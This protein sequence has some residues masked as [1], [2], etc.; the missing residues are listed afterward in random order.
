MK[1]TELEAINHHLQG[2][3]DCSDMANLFCLLKMGHCCQQQNKRMGALMSSFRRANLLFIKK[4]QEIPKVSTTFQKAFTVAT[5][6]SKELVAIVINSWINWETEGIDLYTQ[7]WEQASNS[8]ERKFWHKLLITSKICL[9]TAQR[10]KQKYAPQNSTAEDTTV[11][12]T[13]NIRQRMQEKLAA[14][15]S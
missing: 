8:Y 1:E 5:P 7:L 11:T 2:I 14:T 9:Q 13:V 15:Q 6:N 3:M 10:C 4:Y 12:P